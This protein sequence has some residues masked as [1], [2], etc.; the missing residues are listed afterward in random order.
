MERLCADDVNNFNTFQRW[1]R[2]PLPLSEAE[3]DV[4]CLL[5]GLQLKITDDITE[6]T[7]F[8]TNTNPG[9]AHVKSTEIKI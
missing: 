9:S 8:S 3:R 7:E 6:I 4:I 2:P 5:P 1:I